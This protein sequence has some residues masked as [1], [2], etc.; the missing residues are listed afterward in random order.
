MK[1]LTFEKETPNP[2]TLDIDIGMKYHTVKNIIP[3]VAIG[4]DRDANDLTFHLGAVL[5]TK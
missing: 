1:I 5:M 3:G 2:I 4:G